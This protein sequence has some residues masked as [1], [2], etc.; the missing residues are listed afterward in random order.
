MGCN[1]LVINLQVE[2]KDSK[3]AVRE[4]RREAETGTA[5]WA[6]QKR[7]NSQAAENFRP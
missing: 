2:A 6:L 3:E 7:R 4:G 5:H 1:K